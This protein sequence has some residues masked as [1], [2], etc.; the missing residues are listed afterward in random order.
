MGEIYECGALH[1]R[2][3][4]MQWVKL[5]KMGIYQCE[6]VYAAGVVDTRIYGG[7]QDLRVAAE[8]DAAHRFVHWHRNAVAKALLVYVSAACIPALRNGEPI[9]VLSGA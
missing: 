1:R 8:R 9:L 5:W 6:C 2:G 7:F 3:V 4:A